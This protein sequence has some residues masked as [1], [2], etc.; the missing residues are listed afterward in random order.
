MAA[1]CLLAS[2]LILGTLSDRSLPQRPLTTGGYRVLAA[3]FH[4]HAFPLSA[5][6]IAPWDIVLEA[7]RQGL[8][9]I[10]M[11]GHNQV[12]SGKVARWF[13]AL[14]GGPT[15]LAGEE[16]HG[17]RFHLIAVGIERTISW[18]LNADE[19]I[20]EV[21]RQGGVAIAAHPMS[22]AWPAFDAAAIAQLDGTEVLQPIAYSTEEHRQEL[23]EFY[24]RTGVAAIGSSDYHG[25]GP[26]GLCRTY[27]FVRENSGRGILEALRARRT[28]VVDRG[29]AYGDPALIEAS[30]GRLSGEPPGRGWLAWTSGILGFAG[31]L[32]AV[33]SSPRR[34]SSAG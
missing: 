6:T 5:S 13:S 8:D 16:I 2:A 24:R 34:R 4:V 28:V 22:R 29:R 15:V 27:V 21:H 7:R 17:P 19:A 9:A 33:L 11:T 32:A 10:A 20:A 23:E 26:L 1:G 18:R 25:Q 14:T 31:M 30:K 12:W 3:D